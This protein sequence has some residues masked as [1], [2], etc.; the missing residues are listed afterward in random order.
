[1]SKAKYLKEIESAQEDSAAYVAEKQEREEGKVL[2]EDI[3]GEL[4]EGGSSSAAPRNGS[5]ASDMSHEESD[6]KSNEEFNDQSD[7]SED[8]HE[9]TEARTKL[10]S[11]DTEDER[12]RTIFIRNLSF[13]STEEGLKTFFSEFGRVEYARIVYDKGTG[14]SKGVA[15]IRFRSKVVADSVLAQSINGLR[16]DNSQHVKNKRNSNFNMLTNGDGLVFDGRELILSRSVSKNDA[17]RLAEENK[18]TKKTKDKR[19]LYLAHE[20]T[21]Q[22]NKMSEEELNLPKIDIEK[23]RRA[24]RE[25]KEKLQNPLFFVSPIR[26]SVRN[27]A[28]SIGKILF[29]R[30]HFSS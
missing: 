6:E 27:L 11:E 5:V 19:N 16:A 4:R 18:D 8:D 7:Q 3:S 13:Q 12:N 15:F 22:V 9:V 23:R 10:S 1:M 30:C 28:P 20:G 2:P 29:I 26:L 24:I 17:D 25:K 21:I 14:L